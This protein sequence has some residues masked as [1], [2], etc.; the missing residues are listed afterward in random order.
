MN[1]KRIKMLQTNNGYEKKDNSINQ[2]W[3]WKEEEWNKWMINITR[4]K[5]I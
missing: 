5:I 4:N 1:I 3:F 2:W